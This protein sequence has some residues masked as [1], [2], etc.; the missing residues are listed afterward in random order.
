MASTRE[1]PTIRW[2]HVY[3]AA[4]FNDLCLDGE[5]KYHEFH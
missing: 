5:W 1:H 4:V 3:T 2:G